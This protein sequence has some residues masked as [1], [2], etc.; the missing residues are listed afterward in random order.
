MMVLGILTAKF[1]KKVPKRLLK[2]YLRSDSRIKNQ[3]GHWQLIFK[4]QG[5]NPFRTIIILATRYFRIK[6]W[7]TDNIQKLW[8]KFLKTVKNPP[9]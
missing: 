2:K 6:W 3:D 1:I 8:G 5:G 9:N 4:E 7:F